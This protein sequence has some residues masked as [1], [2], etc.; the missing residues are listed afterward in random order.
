MLTVET[1]NH[2]Y[3]FEVLQCVFES[4]NIKINIIYIPEVLQFK[5]YHKSAM[6]SPLNDY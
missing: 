2:N 1:K 5:F 6:Q 4:F 3:C